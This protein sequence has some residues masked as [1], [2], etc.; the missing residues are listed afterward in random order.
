MKKKIVIGVVLLV[1]GA[2]VTTPNVTGISVRYGFV[3][4]TFVFAMR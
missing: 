4:E 2:L 1:I 3:A